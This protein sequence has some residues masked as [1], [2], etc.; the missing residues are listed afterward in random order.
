MRTRSVFELLLLYWALLLALAA[1]AFFYTTA[2]TP[3]PPLQCHYSWKAMRCPEGCRGSGLFQCAAGASSPPAA[4]SARS[5]PVDTNKA[6]AARRAP[7]AAMGCLAAADAFEAAAAAA[8]SPAESAPLLLK[9]A[10]AL[11]C[12]MRITGDGNILLVHGTKDTPANKKYWALHG[13]RALALVRSVS[14]ADSTLGLSS[15]AVA[16]EM[17]AFMY[18]SSSKGII[19]QALTGAGAEFK[20]LAELLISD[21][22]LWDNGVGYCYLGGFYLLAPWPL[23]DKAKAAESF[24]SSVKLGPSSRRNRYN[25]CVATLQAGEKEAAANCAAALHARCVGG[26]EPDYCDAMTAALARYVVQAKALG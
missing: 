16:T 19:R 11:N 8:A 5:A 24:A 25:L 1:R 2:Y 6:E 12:A 15:Y 7:R 20:R 17:D 4:P 10:D 23:G 14:H 3:P 21:H 22:E 9:A 18:A 13:P 26:T